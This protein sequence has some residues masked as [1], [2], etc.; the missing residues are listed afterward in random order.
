MNDNVFS[1]RLEIS[2]PNLSKLKGFLSRN[3]TESE[4]KLQE[5]SYSNLFLKTM[6][7]KVEVGR[8]VEDFILTTRYNLKMI[9][10]KK[11]ENMKLIFVCERNNRQKDD[12]N[13]CSTVKRKGLSK[14]SVPD[15]CNFRLSFDLNLSE[16]YCF[17]D[18]KGDF[19]NHEPYSKVHC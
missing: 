1:S 2:K 19:H 14:R 13:L 12:D 11:S 15:P 16:V 5:I 7:N 6:R 17:S 4:Q 3:Y 18:I 9:R 8:C 10:P